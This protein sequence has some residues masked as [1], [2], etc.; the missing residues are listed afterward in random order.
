VRSSFQ[1]VMQ[2]RDRTAVDVSERQGRVLRTL[3]P[4]L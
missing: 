4:G 2:D 1:L 3:I